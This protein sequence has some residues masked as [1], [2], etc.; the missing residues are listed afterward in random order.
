M[1]NAALA[2]QARRLADRADRNYLVAGMSAFQLAEDDTVLDPASA[3]FD[4]SIV[5]RGIGEALSKYHD[6]LPARRRRGDAGLLTALAYG[7]GAG[8]MTSD[9]WPSPG[10]SAT[11]TSRRWSRGN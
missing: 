8:S 6:R 7:R 4:P 1:A 2:D 5:P 10:R 9:G 3:R 11:R